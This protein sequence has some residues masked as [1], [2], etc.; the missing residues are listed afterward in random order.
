MSNELTLES[1]LVELKNDL[2]QFLPVKDVIDLSTE[3]DNLVVID[4]FLEGESTSYAVMVITV[5]FNSILLF[6]TAFLMFFSYF[7]VCNQRVVWDALVSAAYEAAADLPSVPAMSRILLSPFM[8]K[9]ITNYMRRRCDKFGNLYIKQ[10]H[11]DKVS[12]LTMYQTTAKATARIFLRSQEI[13]ILGVHDKWGSTVIRG[14]FEPEDGFSV[15]EAPANATQDQK[16][17]RGSCQQMYY[18]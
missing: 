1:Y 18:T 15:R 5:H 16:N 4:K 14:D 2:S 12:G 9:T 7:D 17:G 10:K 13:K 3:A 8:E 6:Y 11:K